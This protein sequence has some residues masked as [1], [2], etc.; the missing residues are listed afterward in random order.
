MYFQ[1]KIAFKGKETT[2]LEAESTSEAVQGLAYSILHK[3]G[4]TAQAT[5]SKKRALLRDWQSWLTL[6]TSQPE[7]RKY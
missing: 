7:P 2:V 5:I 6:S 1:V 4:N 3:L